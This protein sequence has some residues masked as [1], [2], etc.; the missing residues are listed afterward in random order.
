MSIVHLPVTARH[1]IKCHS[2]CSGSSLFVVTPRALVS[3]CFCVKE[4]DRVIIVQCKYTYPYGYTHKL[5]VS[6]KPMRFNVSVEA[7]TPRR[8]LD[9]FAQPTGGPEGIKLIYGIIVAGGMDSRGRDDKEDMTKK[10][11]QLGLMILPR[12]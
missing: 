3:P 7:A 8:S 1:L 5:L 12:I 2:V 10:T 6:V 4:G 11:K 9:T